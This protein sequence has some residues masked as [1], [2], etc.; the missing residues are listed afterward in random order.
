MG[1]KQMERGFTPGADL[2]DLIMRLVGGRGKYASPSER[3]ETDLA[4]TKA[5]QSQ[6]AKAQAKQRQVAEQKTEA[7]TEAF[8]LK[9]MQDAERDF[10]A[11][12][13]KGEQQRLNMVDDVTEARL[14]LVQ[15]AGTREL[16]LLAVKQGRELREA[17]EKGEDKWLLKERHALD[18]A[19]VLA[20]RETANAALL[21][22]P[23]P[24]Y[25]SRSLMLTR[26]PGATGVGGGDAERA[27]RLLDETTRIRDLTTRGTAALEKIAAK[28]AGG[29]PIEI[30]T[31]GIN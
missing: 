7:D 28:L 24:T 26:A 4:A 31:E 21:G 25:E 16:A 30:A 23:A 29:L 3:A 10:I 19:G 18:I 12:E 6:I 17:E 8:H 15:D 5:R 9:F 14:K 11:A 13:R 2:A 20:A 1:A 27:K 22:K